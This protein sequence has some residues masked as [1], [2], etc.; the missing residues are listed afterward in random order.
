VIAT[1]VAGIPELVSPDHGGWLIP[2]GDPEAL[3]GAMIDCL[4]AG[5][6]RLSTVAAAGRQRVLQNHDIR[7]ECA[8]LLAHFGDCG[9]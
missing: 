8:R 4:Q 7:T 2:A 9:S 3:A 1:S 5:H 6:D